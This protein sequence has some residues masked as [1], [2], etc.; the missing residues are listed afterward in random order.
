MITGVCVKI[1]DQG[2]HG[3]HVMSDLAYGA[4]SIGALWLLERAVGEKPS[5]GLGLAAGLG[6]GAGL[7]DAV[8][9]TGVDSG[10]DHRDGLA[11]PVAIAG[12]RG[13]RRGAGRGGMQVVAG[14]GKR[15]ALWPT[16]TT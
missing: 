12:G 10:N 14:A 5:P 3:A 7:P 4:I 2:S 11:T 9:G 13:D 15:C 1:A 6:G 16:N 8:G